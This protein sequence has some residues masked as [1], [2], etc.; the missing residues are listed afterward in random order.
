[1]SRQGAPALSQRRHWEAEGIV[2][3][4]VP[5]PV[6]A[7]RTCSSVVVPEIEGGVPLS[8][9]A[10]ATTADW[11]ELALVV[12]PA[13]VATTTPRMVLPTS[14]TARAYEAPVWPA[15]SVQ[16]LPELSQRCHLWA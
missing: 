11:A 7:V 12:P 16:A 4:A 13:L 10:G 6:A 3:G 8:G 9:R 15:M 1:M 14:A 2:G 5:G